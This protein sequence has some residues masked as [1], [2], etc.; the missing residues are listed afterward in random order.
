MHMHSLRDLFRTAIP[1][2]LLLG[3]ASP[4]FIHNYSNAALPNPFFALFARVSYKQLAIVLLIIVAAK[5]IRERLRK[6]L[7]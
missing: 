3:L 6:R 4:L 5:V 1:L 7:H 2:V